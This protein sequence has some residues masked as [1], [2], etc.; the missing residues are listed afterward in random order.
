MKKTNYTNERIKIDGDSGRGTAVA[1][2]W[3]ALAKLFKVDD[4]ADEIRNPKPNEHTV[5]KAKANR[6][7]NAFKHF[8]SE[9]VCFTA[10]HSSPSDTNIFYVVKPEHPNV[11]YIMELMT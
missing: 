9:K 5:F 2:D 11:I 6:L 8:D 4:Y 3:N 10:R 1:A 7:R